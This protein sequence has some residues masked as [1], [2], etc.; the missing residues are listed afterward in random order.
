ML[1]RLI[2]TKTM[3]AM[4]LPPANTQAS[5]RVLANQQQQLHRNLKCKIKTINRI[6][7]EKRGTRINVKNADISLISK[8]S[9][10]MGVLTFAQKKQK[11]Y[12]NKPIVSSKDDRHQQQTSQ[13]RSVCWAISVQRGAIPLEC[14]NRSPK[15]KTWG[16]FFPQRK[17]DKNQRNHPLD[18]LAIRS[19]KSTPTRNL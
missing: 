10:N 16:L 12:A 1:E 8:P 19:R 13:L 6:K 4:Y 18:T 15:A 5:R 3:T 2:W 11:T 7:A 14:G 17:R 9:A